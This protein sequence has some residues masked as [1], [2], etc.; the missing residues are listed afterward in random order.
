MLHS[1]KALGGLIW[2]LLLRHSR[3]ANMFL[4]SRDTHI[5]VETGCGARGVGG[6]GEENKA[7]V[8]RK[9]FVKGSEAT[10]QA[11]VAVKL[12]NSTRPADQFHLL[13][14]HTHSSLAVSTSSSTLISLSLSLCVCARAF[15][16]TGGEVS[17]PTGCETSDPPA[18]PSLSQ[19]AS[20]A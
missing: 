4:S 9:H 11:P 20:F 19:S 12:G 7:W 15:L 14:T 18:P 1:R 13:Q 5:G 16:P 10:V 8:D 17:S 2:I 6:E 3:A